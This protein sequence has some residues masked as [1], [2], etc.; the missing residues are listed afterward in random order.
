M[1]KVINLVLFV[2]LFTLMGSLKIYAAPLEKQV[3]NQESLSLDA[4]DSSKDDY[5]LP[6]TTSA[7]LNIET[8]DNYV[9]LGQEFST[10]VVLNNVK[11]IYMQKTLQ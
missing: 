7:T 8:L 5:L 4:I 1:K 2:T 6:I 3:P 9:K 10:D 11:D